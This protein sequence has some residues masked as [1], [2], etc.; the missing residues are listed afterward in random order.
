MHVTIPVMIRVQ[1]E[2]QELRC[3]CLEHPIAQVTTIQ[4]AKLNVKLRVG[5][6]IYNQG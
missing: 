4:N 1:T 6:T 3:L 2:I 5:V